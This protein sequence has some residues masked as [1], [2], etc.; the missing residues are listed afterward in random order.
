MAAA[1]GNDDSLNRRL[2]NQARLSFAA[3]DAV[4]QLKKTL[5]AIGVDVIGDRGTAQ[6]NGFPQ[7]FLD[8]KVEPAQ[9]LARK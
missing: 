6:R 3:I 4:M 9:V 7:D 1:S 8:G 2:T 5:C